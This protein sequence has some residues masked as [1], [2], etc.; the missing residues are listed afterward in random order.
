[1]TL[2]ALL[3]MVP[4][5]KVCALDRGRGFSRYISNNVRSLRPVGN[6]FPT[7]DIRFDWRQKSD[8]SHIQVRL[9]NADYRQCPVLEQENTIYRRGWVRLGM[10]SHSVKN[11]GLHLSLSAERTGFA[12]N[13]GRIT[14]SCDIVPEWTGMCDTQRAGCFPCPLVEHRR[15][16]IM[17]VRQTV[18]WDAG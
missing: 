2:D 7:T 8:S 14:G 18:S 5:N 4:C 16:G 15:K 13:E 1:M 12:G 10:R 11:G 6:L 9:D 3:H 17:F